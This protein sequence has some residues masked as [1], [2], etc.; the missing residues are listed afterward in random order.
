MTLS[1][2]FCFWTNAELPPLVRLKMSPCFRGM[3][4]NSSLGTELL[5]DTPDT[6]D[7]EERGSW[8]QILCHDFIMWKV[9]YQCC[10]ANVTKAGR[11]CG[12][13]K[14]YP[15][16]SVAAAR[17][18]TL[19]KGSPAKGT[20]AVVT[21]LRPFSTKCSRIPMKR[22]WEETQSIDKKRKIFSFSG[23]LSKMN[24]SVFD[25][26]EP[27]ECLPN[28][29]NILAYIS[30]VPRVF[31]KKKGQIP[32]VTRWMTDMKRRNPASSLKANL[33]LVSGTEYFYIWLPSNRFHNMIA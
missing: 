33:P 15:H 19:P 31:S 32:A 3:A 6:P 29:W 13:R 23:L 9:L 25:R 7:T 14:K 27:I 10:G 18:W 16:S 22:F 1:L 20:W 2:H 24:S 21:W 5:P 4:Q 28:T 17:S 12:L 8:W 30:A 11:R 26:K